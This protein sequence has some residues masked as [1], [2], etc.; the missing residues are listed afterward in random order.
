MTE[1]KMTEKEVDL[2]IETDEMTGRSIMTDMTDGEAT[3]GEGMV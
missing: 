2:E 3:K 1:K